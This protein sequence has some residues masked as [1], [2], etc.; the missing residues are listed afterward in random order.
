MAIEKK[1]LTGKKLVTKKSTTKTAQPAAKLHTAGN[2][3]LHI[4]TGKFQPHG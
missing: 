1:S 4:H 2:A 3:T